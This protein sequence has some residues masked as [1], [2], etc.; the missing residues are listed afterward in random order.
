[1]LSEFDSA[2]NTI[3]V[4]KGHGQNPRILYHEFT[5]FALFSLATLPSS[6]WS[7]RLREIE[8]GLANY[9]VSSFDDNPKIWA[10]PEG[11][12]A[13][14]E[15]LYSD[16]DE[17]RMIPP[18]GNEDLPA[19]GGMAWG[20]AFWEVRRMLGKSAVDQMLLN[21]WKSSAAAIIDDQS[22]AVFM[23]QFFDAIRLQAGE[24]TRRQVEAIFTS[25]GWTA[26]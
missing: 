3:S 1:M 16:L 15:T 5:H 22:D 13:V 21:S 20:S 7:H 6:Q 14:S 24:E 2:S 23:R 19:I 11:Q 17:P 10:L 12:E 18:I 25:R 9:F 4:A 8:A 26:Q